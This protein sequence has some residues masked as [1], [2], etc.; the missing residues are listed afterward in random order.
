MPHRAL[1]SAA[2]P[3]QVIFPSTNNETGK[4]RRVGIIRILEIVFWCYRKIS[5]LNGSV[6]FRVSPPRIHHGCFSRDVLC[7]GY[8]HR[9]VYESKKVVEK[10]CLHEKDGFEFSC[11]YV[12]IL[13]VYFC[14]HL[15]IVSTLSCPILVFFFESF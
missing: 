11:V 15:I 8:L 5:H 7:D 3:L 12:C 9:T 6:F 1:H 4:E 10:I 2:S 14:R 13:N